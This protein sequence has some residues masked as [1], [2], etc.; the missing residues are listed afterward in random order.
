M[1]ECPEREREGEG[2]NLSSQPVRQTNALG[3]FD[4]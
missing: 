1:Y 3:I 4:A 2:E